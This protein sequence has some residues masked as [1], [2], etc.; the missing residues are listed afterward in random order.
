MLKPLQP[1]VAFLYT[2]K[3]KIKPLGFLMFSGGIEKQH[4]AVMGWATCKRYFTKQ[5]HNE[6][7]D[8]TLKSIFSD[9]FQHFFEVKLHLRF[10]NVK[11]HFIFLTLHKKSEEITEEILNGKLHFLCSVKQSRLLLLYSLFPWGIISVDSSASK[12][13]IMNFIKNWEDQNCFYLRM[14]SWK[15]GCI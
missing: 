10:N 9:H 7:H 11:I 2:L 1:G 15:Q 13:N 3:K 14:K 12:E 8:E 4:R 5:L 6:E